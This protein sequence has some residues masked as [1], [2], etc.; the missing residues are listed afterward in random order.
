[1]NTI[2]YSPEIC[3]LAKQKTYTSEEFSNLLRIIVMTGLY[4]SPIINQINFPITVTSRQTTPIYNQ[5]QQTYIYNSFNDIIKTDKL[6]DAIESFNRGNASG[7]PKEFAIKYL[8][9]LLAGSTN[10]KGYDASTGTR[11]VEIKTETYNTY[12]KT[13]AKLN[14]KIIYS[15]VTPERYAIWES[16][17]PITI[18][19]GFID[20]HLAYIIATEFNNISCQEKRKLASNIRR[21]NISFNSKDLVNVPIHVIYTSPYIDKVLTKKYFTKNMLNILNQA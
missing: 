7:I 10:D 16:G 5:S 20:E 14:G 12:A 15:N 4:N 9:N 21:Q 3:K 13:P 18:I 11:F 1:M 2:S 6:S 19:C 8:L 17:N